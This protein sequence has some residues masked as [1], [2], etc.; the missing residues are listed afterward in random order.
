MANSTAYAD[1]WFGG[2]TPC[3]LEGPK[4]WDLCYNGSATTLREYNWQIHP[5]PHA[6]LQPTA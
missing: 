6:N 2:I 5:T 3:V 1:Q 4:K